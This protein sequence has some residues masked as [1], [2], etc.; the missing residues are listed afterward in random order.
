MRA[1]SFGLV[2]AFLLVSGVANAATM[3]FQVIDADGIKV[4]LG[5]GEI[6]PNSD[7]AFRAALR[8]A[9][10]GTPVILHSPGGNLAGGVRLGLA[11]RET[12]TNVGVA[13]GGACFSAC[14]YALLGGVNRM[15]LKGGQY[16]VHS[17]ATTG[18]SSKRKPTKNEI[19]EDK[20]V[21]RF[22]RKYA[23]TLGVSPDLIGVA[24]GTRHKDMKILS[25]KELRKMRVITDG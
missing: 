13:P 4:L 9:G 15:V 16:G 18:R 2:L 7:R 20:E 19:A 23:R 22:L 25:K 12:G 5:E 11:F 10:R 17:F 24:E 1:R 8:K 3:K 21:N 14:A 6:A